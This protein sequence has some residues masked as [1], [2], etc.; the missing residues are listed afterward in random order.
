M[1]MLLANLPK[2]YQDLARGYI[3]QN[4]RKSISGTN[5]PSSPI[6]SSSPKLLLSPQQYGQFSSLQNHV[7]SPRSRQT[8]VEVDHPISHEEVYKNLRKTTAEIQNYSFESK[9][10][11]DANSKDSGISQM[12]DH[13]LHAPPNGFNANGHHAGSIEKDDSINGSSKTQSAATTESNTPENTVRLENMQ[14]HQNFTIENNEVILESKL[15]P[16]CA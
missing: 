8:S 9:L 15:L 5:S 14:K 11:R 7:S 1:T 13:L 6:S 4:T 12:G 16:V 10:D 2:Q 3:Q